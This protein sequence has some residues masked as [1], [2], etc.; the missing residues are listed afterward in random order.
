[1]TFADLAAFAGRN[2]VLSL[3]LVG[4]TVAIIVNEILGLLSGVR[5]IG[6]AQLTAL[7]NRDNALVVDLRAIGDFEKGHIAGAKNV[8]M[9][10]FDPENK[11]LAPAK[12]LPVVLVCQVGQTATTA[13]K[14]LRKAGFAQ[15]A[16]LEGG[17][18]AWQSADLPLV[19]GR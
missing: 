1:M 2:P 11:A 8:Q 14:R 7:V 9:S 18:Q 3:A 4:L 15:V 5:R 10:Q 19:K 16:V 6:P 12:S 13:A 17:I